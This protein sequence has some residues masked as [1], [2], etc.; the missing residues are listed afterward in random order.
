MK[1]KHL[2][3][4]VTSALILTAGSVQAA[5]PQSFNYVEFHYVVA[6][7]T[8]FN[9]SGGSSESL[10][11][12]RGYEVKAAFELND[13]FFVMGETLQLD[14]DDDAIAV[15][16]ES[17]A[18]AFND[19]TFIGVGAH[20]PVA[21]MVEVYGA[22]GLIRPMF[23]NFAGDG[24]GLKLGG[25][26]SAGMADIDLWYQM[27]RAKMDLDGTSVDNDP[28]MFGLDVAISF[29]PDAPQLVLGYTDAT[30]EIDTGGAGL[31]VDQ[32][33]NHFSIG[34]RKTF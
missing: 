12:V 14:Y 4:C 27:G 10:D 30:F 20:V 9:I 26:V 5:Q 17:D 28:S 7:D 33:F 31:D 34:V 15:V 2:L 29:A 1:T 16:A 21:D 18:A 3:L 23:L 32:E 13:M 19:Y 11:L 25:K 8:T 6:G 22:L 24:F